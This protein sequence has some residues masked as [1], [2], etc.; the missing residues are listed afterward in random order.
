MAPATAV[1]D[2]E[3]DVL[4]AALS[5]AQSYGF[6]ISGQDLQKIEN[7]S[8]FPGLPEICREAIGWLEKHSEV[9]LA[10]VLGQTYDRIARTYI[11]NI[12]ADRCR[13]RLTISSGELSV[14]RLSNSEFF[15]KIHIL[16]VRA[17]IALA[18]NGNE[19]DKYSERTLRAA[20]DSLWQR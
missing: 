14:W 6:H 17:M 3:Y 8:F 1:S 13:L 10:S 19:E 18:K 7:R 20:C 15:D 5:K 2:S 4:I 11:V 12:I 16:A 9:E